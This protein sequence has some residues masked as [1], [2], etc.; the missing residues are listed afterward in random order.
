VIPDAAAA[1]IAAAIEDATRRGHTPQQ[2][3]TRA[4]R[5]LRRA[6]WHITP[7]HAPTGRQTGTR[8]AAA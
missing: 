7:A 2:A 6:G 4:V 5:D 1:V 8:D 3:A